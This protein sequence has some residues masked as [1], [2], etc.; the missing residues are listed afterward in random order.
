MMT[1]INSNDCNWGYSP[2]FFIKH[3]NYTKMS[4]SK[5]KNVSARH[6]LSTNINVVDVHATYWLLIR[7]SLSAQRIVTYVMCDMLN[8]IHIHI[9]LRRL[10]PFRT[11][12]NFIINSDLYRT[13]FWYVQFD[14]FTQFSDMPFSLS[15]YVKPLS[16]FHHVFVP[17]TECMQY[18]YQHI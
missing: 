4:N 14:W 2:I 13:Y 3:F 10:N 5:C 18:S 6:R 9:A 1:I 7:S 17:C 15:R 11:N 16:K 8:H 12:G